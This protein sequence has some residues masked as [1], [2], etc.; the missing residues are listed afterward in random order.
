MWLDFNKNVITYYVTY[1]EQKYDIFMRD[2]WDHFFII[3]ALS[4]YL[5]L[6][7]IWEAI[8]LLVQDIHSDKDCSAEHESCVFA[9]RVD[10]S[11][12][13]EG[14]LS[15]SIYYVLLSLVLHGPYLEVVQIILFVINKKYIMYTV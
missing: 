11:V 8:Y 12:T 6:Y 7:A 3:Q 5:V 2:N 15:V 14:T 1:A 4:F 9:L 10:A 13:L